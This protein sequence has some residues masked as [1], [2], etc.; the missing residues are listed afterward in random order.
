[1]ERRVKAERAMNRRALAKLRKQ[2]G[3]PPLPPSG[4]E[5]IP[6]E[7]SDRERSSLS[8]VAHRKAEK[9]R[10][11]SAEQEAKR[12]KKLIERKS[13]TRKITQLTPSGQPRMRHTIKRLLDKIVS[14]A[15][16]S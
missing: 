9:R 12:Q 5:A 1:M 4:L 10:A 15:S 8:E 16:S 6:E 13:A 14:T 11:D 7:T 3:L 2:Q